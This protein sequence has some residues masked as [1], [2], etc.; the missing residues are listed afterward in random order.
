M[1]E[2]ILKII[3]IY[4]LVGAWIGIFVV[5]SA[6]VVD[7]HT[8][9][10]GIDWLIRVLFVTVSWGILLPMYIRYELLD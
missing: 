6:F 7:K 4:L 3:G 10:S 8:F 2:A 1:W 5:N 9:R